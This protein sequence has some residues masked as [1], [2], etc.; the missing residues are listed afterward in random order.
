[1]S[2]LCSVSVSLQA[3]IA[4]HIHVYIIIQMYTVCPRTHTANFCS[5]YIYIFTTGQLCTRGN[6]VVYIHVL[7]AHAQNT[8]TNSQ[9]LQPCRIIDYLAYVYI[10]DGTELP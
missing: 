9:Q 1:M 8:M 10:L 4:V 3:S 7:I 2:H 5:A 6:Y